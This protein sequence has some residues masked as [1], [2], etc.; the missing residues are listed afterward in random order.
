M[1]EVFVPIKGYE[2]SYEISN[3]GRVRS[4]MRKGRFMKLLLQPSGYYR[5][6]LRGDG[7]QKSFFVHRLVASHFVENNQDKPQ[8]NHIDGN[9]LNN[10]YSNLEWVTP[11]ENY[12]HA[13]SIG[14]HESIMAENHCN[15]K[16]TNEQVVEIRKRRQQGE[17][18][19]S[20]AN[21]FGMAKQNIY[22]LC[23]GKTWRSV[24]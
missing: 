22:S 23:T 7:P 5:V 10:D 9:K 18:Y 21:H 4:K 11:Y 17:T 20:L 2:G 13:R 24:V 1:E 16:L 19:N 12:H 15:S 3:K 8:V 14:L 6:G